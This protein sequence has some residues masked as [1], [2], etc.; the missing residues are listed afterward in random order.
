MTTIPIG[1]TLYRGSYKEAA[2]AKGVNKP[3]YLKNRPYY[4]LFNTNN[5]NN[6]KNIANRA[7]GQVT[8]YKTI[9]QLKLINMSDPMT[10]MSLLRKANN[11]EVITKSILKTFRIVNSNIIRSSKLKYDVHVA[12]F[13]CKLGMDGYWAPKLKQKYGNKKFHQEI[14]LCHPKAALRVSHVEDP[15]RAQSVAPKKRIRSFNNNN[16]GN[17]RRLMF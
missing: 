11:D 14:V 9:K 2:V 17:V 12:N 3:N 5:N 6:G 1:F 15:S 10:I 8:V 16:T 7:Y 13:I 4:F